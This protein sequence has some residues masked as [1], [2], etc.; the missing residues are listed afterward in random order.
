MATRTVCRGIALLAAGL[1]LLL[2]WIPAAHASHTE[3]SYQVD[4]FEASSVATFVDEFDD[5]NISGW[6]HPYGTAV[7]SDGVL[8][9]SNP[10]DHDSS[11]EECCSIML[12][13]SGVQWPSTDLAS[14][15]DDFYAASWWE[16]IIPDLPGG[17]Y[18]MFLAYPTVGDDWS[19]WEH[20]IVGI[21]N[22]SAEISAAMG[23]PEGLFVGQAHFSYSGAAP[24]EL[25]SFYGVPISAGEVTGDIVFKIEFDHAS[26]QLSSAFSL[27]GGTIFSAP[28]TAIDA[29][30]AQG[31]HWNLY[32][33]PATYIPEPS[34][35]L[36]L[37]PGLAG[38]AAAG[39]R[40]RLT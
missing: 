13:S 4:R 6:L 2:T 19:E 24:A 38:L 27:D 14:F 36:L 26:N 30:P 16:P 3:F 11:Y 5:G 29:P 23:A 28:F 10:G 17:F 32:G 1:L 15:H 35:A 12:D 21:G 37:A 9:L 8:T 18:T 20:L 40:H 31:G 22:W 34:T 7:E 33:D 25:L 39:R